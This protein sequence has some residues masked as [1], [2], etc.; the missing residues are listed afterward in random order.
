M[1][2]FSSSTKS[3]LQPYFLLMTLFCQIFF[4]L[5]PTKCFALLLQMAKTYSRRRFYQYNEGDCRFQFLISTMLSNSLD[6]HKHWNKKK[7]SIISFSLLSGKLV[8]LKKLVRNQNLIKKSSLFY[9]YNADHCTWCHVNH[10]I[11]TFA[12][13][14]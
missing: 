14:R 7:L 6:V 1:N 2:I 13:N 3:F 12:N 11:C 10:G 4:C 5:I 8:I 9:W